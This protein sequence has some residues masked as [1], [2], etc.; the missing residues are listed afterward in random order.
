MNAREI[1]D[2][3]RSLSVLVVGDICLDRWCIYDPALDQASCET[4]IR[5]VAVVRVQTTPGAGGTIAN[6]LAALGAARIDVLGVSGEDGSAW[7]LK[8]ALT[9]A[10]IGHEW[11]IASSSSSTFTYTKLLNA[12]SG[13]EDRPRVD[14]VNAAPL[15]PEIECRV[16]AALNESVR[17]YDV[18][19]FSDQAESNCGGVITP[20]VRSEIERLAGNHRD[21]IFWVDSRE[22][23][24]VFRRV[25]VKPNYCEA[26]AACRR[27]FGSVDLARLRRHIE[28]PLLVVTRGADGA[29]L[30]TDGRCEEVP[31]RPNPSPVDICGAGD[32]FSAGA[33]MALA[34]TGS[35][36]EAVRVGNAVAS[37]T[38]T[39]SGTGTATPDEVLEALAWS[40]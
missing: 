20:T 27:L 17:N 40:V 5:R 14:Y 34:V 36:L 15:A 1:L 32:S 4:G 30:F 19:L 10:G 28:A 26:E 18:I 21:K 2:G 3:F 37:V 35:P 7:E 6:N 22:R 23:P 31:T 39:K 8:R 29:L 13:L 11:L 24:E 38:I 16:I 25:V 9:A 12:T 33:S